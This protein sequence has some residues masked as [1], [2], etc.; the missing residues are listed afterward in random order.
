MS[1]VRDI[2]REIREEY[3]D[4]RFDAKIVN[5]WEY[6]DVQI[7]IY[8]LRVLDSKLYIITKRVNGNEYPLGIGTT[9]CTALKD[10][11]RWDKV[12]EQIVKSEC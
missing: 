2:S 10:A 11:S 8:S 9:P 1:Q 4:A 7:I 5:A 12:T 3:K 6:N